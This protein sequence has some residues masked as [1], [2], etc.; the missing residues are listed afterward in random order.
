MHRLM[1]SWS[2]V[3]RA[4]SINIFVVAAV[5]GCYLVSSIKLLKI[6]MPRKPF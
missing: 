1:I 5:L 4:A 6:S 3:A 2:F